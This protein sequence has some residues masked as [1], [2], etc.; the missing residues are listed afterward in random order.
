MP[1]PKHYFKLYPTQARFLD[2]QARLRAFTGG[3][4]AGKSFVG[5]YDL[6]KRLR[7]GRRYCVV[8]PTYPQLRDSSWQSFKQ[9]AG[10]LGMIGPGSVLKQEFMAT[11]KTM[12]GGTAEVT[13]RSAD[14][15]DSLRGP[16]LSGAWL[17]E[18]SYQPEDALEIVYRSLREGGEPGWMTATFT[19]AGFGHWTYK[20]F[21][22]ATEATDPALFRAPTSDNP[23]L[24]PEVY[25]QS[26]ITVSGLRARQELGGEFVQ[27]EGAEWPPEYFPESLWFTE[28]PRSEFVAT[29]L[30]VD[31]SMGKGEKLKGCFC[32]IVFV[33]LTRDKRIW[34]EAWG[35]QTWDA[36][37]LTKAVVEIG[38]LYQPMGILLETNGGQGFLAPLFAIHAR[39]LNYP[40]PLYGK[41][42]FEFKETR[43]RTLGPPL[44][45]GRFRFRDTPGTRLLVQQ[46]RDFPAGEFCDLA[47]C[48]ELSG[49]MLNFILSG[50]KPGGAG[51]P[52][53]LRV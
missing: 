26:R 12:R 25:E 29:A 52:Q 43:I 1:K 47:D 11:V 15:P 3:R 23:F 9:I 39:E 17:D 33:G 16:N 21:G 24:D 35:S 50:K 42:N 22:K 34:V 41:H 44:A 27:I 6:L 49:V 14:R 7:P 4:G 45:Q 30:A 5:A 18:A 46:L 51:Q 13:F 31:P 10:D 37:Q 20:Q 40:I 28:M 32:G 48:L 2:C 38:R 19:P 36:T 8:A 53:V